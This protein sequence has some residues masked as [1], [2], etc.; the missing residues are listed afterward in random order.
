VAADRH[1]AENHQHDH[2]ATHN[3]DTRSDGVVTKDEN[4]LDQTRA[5]P[6]ACT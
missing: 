3:R 1:H 5:K 6:A 2:T 4:V